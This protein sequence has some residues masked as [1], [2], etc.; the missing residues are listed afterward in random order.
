MYQDGVGATAEREH[1]TIT[2]SPGRT[3]CVCTDAG[4]T[5]TLAV[6]QARGAHGHLDHGSPVTSHS[7]QR[8]T[9]VVSCPTSTASGPVASGESAPGIRRAVARSARRTDLHRRPR[10]SAGSAESPRLEIQCASA[11]A[12]WPQARPTGSDR[13]TKAS[14]EA[15]SRTRAAAGHV[16]AGAHTRHPAAAREGTPA[17]PASDYT[18]VGISAPCGGHTT[19]RSDTES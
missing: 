18:H 8:L 12:D 3:G 1:G 2:G 7:G 14:V 5:V 6:D 13:S 19:P 16:R 9:A 11:A 10:A 17:D 4:K 15:F